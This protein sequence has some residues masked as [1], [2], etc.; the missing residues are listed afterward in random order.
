MNQ[1]KNL[2]QKKLKKEHVAHNRFVF[3]AASSLFEVMIAL[4]L[5]VIFQVLMMRTAGV[6]F[7]RLLTHLWAITVY[8]A[9]TTSVAYAR[10]TGVP[11]PI[12]IAPDLTVCCQWQ[13]YTF[14]LKPFVKM[15]GIAGKPLFTTTFPLLN[16]TP[17]IV[18]Y[19]QGHA[20]PGRLTVQAFSDCTYTLSSSIHAQAGWALYHTARHGR[21]RLQ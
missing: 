10:L 16:T 11:V 6:P 17:T 4:A 1:K 14:S 5:V 15:E 9:L 12:T 20:T 8:Y 13:K 2:Y 21:R 3:H 18:C 7:R 19:P